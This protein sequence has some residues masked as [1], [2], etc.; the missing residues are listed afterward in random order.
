MSANISVGNSTSR[1]SAKN[2]NTLP[3]GIKSRHVSDTCGP[4]SS[5]AHSPCVPT[6]LAPTQPRRGH[7]RNVSVIFQ[8][9]REMSTRAM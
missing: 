1:C 4:T 7:N 3:A 2:A 6:T 8:E 5:P 9:T